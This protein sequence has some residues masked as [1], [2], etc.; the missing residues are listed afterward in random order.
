MTNSHFQE[1]TNWN[2]H[3]APMYKVTP[4]VK[5][6]LRN[7]WSYMSQSVRTILSRMSFDKHKA[8]HQL[9]R[10]IRDGIESR[11]RLALI[12]LLLFVHRQNNPLPTTRY[13]Q[14]TTHN[15]RP[16]AHDSPTNAKQTTSGRSDN[17]PSTWS[18]GFQVQFCFFA[19]LTTQ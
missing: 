16:T 17:T 8:M 19:L 6:L 2:A 1:D 3:I 11:S 15:A 13:L 7:I 18:S 4:E 5:Q 9:K 14:G 12:Q 10:L